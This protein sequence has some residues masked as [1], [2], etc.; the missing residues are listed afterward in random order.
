MNP[1]RILPLPPARRKLGLPLLALALATPLTACFGSGDDDVDVATG[2]AGEPVGTTPDGSGL[3]YCASLPDQT[4]SL[5]FGGPQF[6]PVPNGLATGQAL[7]Y[8]VQWPYYVSVW[9]RA[10][11]ESWIIVGVSGGMAEL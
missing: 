10:S 4:D 9:P 2:A 6:S 7:T 3:A 11:Q 5:D 8:A 1:R